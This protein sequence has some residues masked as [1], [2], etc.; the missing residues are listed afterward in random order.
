MGPNIFSRREGLLLSRTVGRWL[1]AHHGHRSA[2]RFEEI[3]HDGYR[4]G[5]GRKMESQSRLPT[6]GHALDKEDHF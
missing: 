2:S 1:R 4:L 5:L 3:S 6:R